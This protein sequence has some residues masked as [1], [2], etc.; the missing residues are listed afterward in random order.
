MLS[1][2]FVM[3]FT[4]L[5]GCIFSLFNCN[6]DV[7]ISLISESI[8]QLHLEDNDNFLCVCLLSIIVFTFL[9]LQISILKVHSILD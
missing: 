8:W 5:N 1:K 7:E 6:L 4:E 9:F 2:V 3:F